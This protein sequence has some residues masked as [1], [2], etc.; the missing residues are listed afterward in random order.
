MRSLNLVTISNVGLPHT[1]LMKWLMLS[2]VL[3]DP[4]CWLALAVAQQSA[5][6]GAATGNVR[7]TV[8]TVDPDGGRSVIT[9]AKVLLEGVTV[10]C[11]NADGVGSR[12]HFL[13]F[14]DTVLS[15]HHAGGRGR[16]PRDQD[17][18]RMDARPYRR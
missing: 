18:W 13:V 16:Q 11:V 10:C 15:R 14:E 2:V 6:A 3:M 7:G 17:R 8:F 1:Q 9:G 4:W 12:R 5:V